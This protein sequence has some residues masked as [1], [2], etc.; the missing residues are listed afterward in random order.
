VGIVE[1]DKTLNLLE[2]GDSDY[3]NEKPYYFE[4][5]R[6]KKGPIIIRIKNNEWYKN[7]NN[8]LRTKT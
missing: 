3:Y 6:K 5:Y 7:C 2:I 8:I 1:K 4:S